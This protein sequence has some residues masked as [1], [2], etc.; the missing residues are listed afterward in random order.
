MSAACPG[1]GPYC[2]GPGERPLN[3]LNSGTTTVLFF[4][5]P[6]C[7]M[8]ADEICELAESSGVLA[9]GARSGNT[10]EL[11]TWSNC[12][13]IGSVRLSGGG[14]RDKGSK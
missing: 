11:V 1:P 9:T 3:T 2:A 12:D 6:I 7:S 13:L 14:A 8:L 10:I 4:P 5:L